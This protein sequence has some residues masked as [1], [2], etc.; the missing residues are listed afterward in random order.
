MILLLLY[1]WALTLLRVCRM[2]NVDMN[3]TPTLSTIVLVITAGRSPYTPGWLISPTLST[4]ALVTTPELMPKGLRVNPFR[5]KLQSRYGDKPLKNSKYSVPKTGLVFAIKGLKLL[6]CKCARCR[7]YS[8]PD[9][10]NRRPLQ[11]SMMGPLAT[12]T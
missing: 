3:I 2:L 11:S 9:G 1:C 8:S 6:A 4:I 5:A 12:A 10:A 7:G